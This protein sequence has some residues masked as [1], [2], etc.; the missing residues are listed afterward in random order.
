MPKTSCSS[1]LKLQNENCW[2]SFYPKYTGEAM[3]P[4][5]DRSKRAVAWLNNLRTGVIN[6]ERAYP[7]VGLEIA[8]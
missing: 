7:E 5:H 2:T 4:I 1:W 3:T 6:K 8:D